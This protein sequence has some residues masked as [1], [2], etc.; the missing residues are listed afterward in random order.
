MGSDAG[1]YDRLTSYENIQ[2]HADLRGLD[3]SIF[4]RRIKKFCQMLQMQDYLHKKSGPF[5][6]GMKQKTAIVRAFIHDPDIMLLDEPT[7]GLDITSALTM[8]QFIR[9]AQTQN[10]TIIFSSHRLDEIYRLGQRVIA[11]QQG[12]VFFDGSV[13]DFKKEKIFHKIFIE[14]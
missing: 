12:Q 2:Y 5:S 3:K 13:K 11:L 14:Q 6:F 8:H 10:K 1:L 4:S 9:Q 7:T